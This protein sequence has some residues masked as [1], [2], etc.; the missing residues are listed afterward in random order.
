MEVPV[1]VNKGRAI[2]FDSKPH[3]NG[4]PGRPRPRWKNNMEMHSTGASIKDV[5]W[6]VKGHFRYPVLCQQYWSYWFKIRHISVLQTFKNGRWNSI[7][8]LTYDVLCWMTPIYNQ[9]SSLPPIIRRETTIR[10][11]NIL[12]IKSCR[13]TSKFEPRTQKPRVSGRNYIELWAVQA[14]RGL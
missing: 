14:W 12:Y 6:G 10:V 13:P 1:N 3:E 5:I 4:Q 2:H 9:R 7:H 11:K 8:I